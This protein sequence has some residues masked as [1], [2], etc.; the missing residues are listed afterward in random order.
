MSLSMA[1]PMLING[2]TAL[3]KAIGFS[4]TV[5]NAYNATAPEAVT[6]LKAAGAAALGGGKS[7]TALAGAIWSAVWPL[8]ALAAAAVAVYAMFKIWKN[9]SPEEQLKRLKERAKNASEAFDATTEAI[10]N[11][12]NALDGLEDSYDKIAN[13]TK[14]TEEWT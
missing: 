13:L 10:S 8:L 4:N 14:G 5:L 2:M 6:S 11:T 1:I 9:S 3:G 12:K 7:F